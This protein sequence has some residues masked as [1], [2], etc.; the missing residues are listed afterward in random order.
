MVGLGTGCRKH[1][2]EAAASVELMLY[3]AEMR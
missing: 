1:E 2:E 3:S